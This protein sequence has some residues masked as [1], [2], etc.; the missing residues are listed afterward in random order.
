VTPERELGSPGMSRREREEAERAYW[1]RI[2]RRRP[3]RV[4]EP[5]PGQESVWD[6]PRPPRVEPARRRVRVELA[7]AVVA[8]SERA[9]RVCETA[10]PPVYYVP[11]ADVRGELLVPSR[12]ESLCE[13]KGRA[14]Y[15]SLR[16]GERVAEDAAWEYPEPDPDYAVL[17]DHLAFYPGRMDA[18]WLDDERVAPQPGDFYGGW[19]TADVVGPFKGEPGTEGW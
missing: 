12:R 16:V 6:Y 9:L 5:G 17:R 14:R 13:W 15:W 11:R 10:G 19:I 8:E 1:R 3:D 4:V 7:G 18:C 2:P